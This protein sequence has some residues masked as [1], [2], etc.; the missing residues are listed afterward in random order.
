MKSIIK[1]IIQA[2][3]KEVFKAK[4]RRP[5]KIILAAIKKQRRQR[6]DFKKSISVQ[7]NISFIGELKKASPVKGHLCLNLDL[8]KTAKLYEKAGINA[9]SVLTDAHFHGKLSDIKKVKKAVNLPVLRKDFIIDEYQI[10]ESYLAGADAV[11]LIASLLS[12]RKLTRMLHILHSL[13]MN[14]LIEVHS[15]RDLN[16]IN[17]TRAEIIGINNRNLENFKVNLKTTE[18]LRKKIPDD[19]TLVSESGINTKKDIRYLQKLGVNAV[20]IGEAIVT[21]KDMAAKI[22]S[23]TG[24]RK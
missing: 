9:I 20:L 18:K 7:K 6:R 2:K 23:F 10:Y 8:V 17:F 4:K 5:L 1:Q 16:N 3:K 19:K 24:K 14:A 12:K 15:K 13:N 22:R 11:L 21:A